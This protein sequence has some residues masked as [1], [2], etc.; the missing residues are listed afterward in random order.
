MQFKY[1]VSTSL[2]FLRRACAARGQVIALGLYIEILPKK[3]LKLK[4]YSILT[5]EGFSS[6]LM[7]SSTTL[8]LGKFSWSSQILLVCHSGKASATLETQTSPSSKP[9]PLDIRLNTP[10]LLLH[11][12]HAL[13][14]SQLSRHLGST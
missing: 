7:A 2:T 10:T 3:K 13:K 5:Q 8:Q 14:Q 12:L 1:L 4:K 11:A 6:N 9:H